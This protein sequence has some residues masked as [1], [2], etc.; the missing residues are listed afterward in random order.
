[1]S[2]TA[3]LLA[4]IVVVTPIEVAY[5]MALELALQN[6]LDYL[7]RATRIVL[8]VTPPGLSWGRKAPYIAIPTVLSP[9]RLIRVEDL[10]RLSS[11]LQL[12]YCLHRVPPH[13]V[14]QL[15]DLP[16]ANGQQ[17]HCFEV[18]LNPQMPPAPAEG[19]MGRR[20]VLRK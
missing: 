4:P 16:A 11:R 10:A 12:F 13:L 7:V 20:M 5:Q 17:M 6:A 14:Q 2:P 18:G 3:L 1:M 8:V 9:T 19:G 15:H